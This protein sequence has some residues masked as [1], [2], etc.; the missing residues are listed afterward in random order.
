MF[1]N[2]IKKNVDNWINSYDCPIKALINYIK[3]K[4]ELR[5][6]QIEAIETYLFLKIKCNNEPLDRIFSK[7]YL[8]TFLNID[9]LEIKSDFRDFLKNNLAAKMLY[10]ISLNKNTDEGEFV[11]LKKEIEKNYN[12]I[13][14]E[15]VF[16]NIFYDTSY[17]DYI[18]SLPMG[19][20]KT[21]L[22]AM[23][24]Y[25]D[26]YFAINEPNNKSFAHNFIILAPS[27]LKS[28]IVP[29]LKTIQNFD[30]SW[31][32]PEPSASS[33]KRLVKFEILDANKS[34][35]KSN[36]T[37]NP[38]VNK[39][40]NY[41]PFDSL[42]GLVM[43]T[44]AEK[45]IL[46][47]IKLNEN[48]QIDILDTSEDEEDKQANE[49]RNLIGKVPNLAIY[50]DEVHHA[51]DDDI[52]LRQVVNSWNEKG[53][54][55]AVVGFSGTP[56]LN[57]KEPIE[58]L[59]NEFSFKTGTLTNV[60]YYYPLIKGIG[61]FLKKPIVKSTNDDAINIVKSGVKEFLEK[62]KDKV[63]KNG[64]TAKLAIYC[65]KIDKL[66]KDIYPKVAEIVSEYGL[67]PNQVILKYHQGNKEFPISTESKTEFLSLDTKISKKKIVLLVQI[68]KEGWDCKSLTGVILSQKG[69][70]PTNMVLQTSCR[71]LRQVIKGENEDAIIWL[72]DFNKKI[73]EKELNNQQHITIKEF[74]AGIK[75]DK[76]IKRIDRTQHL[77]LDK[78]KYIEL[79][80]SYETIIE[81]K[82]SEK[83]I[84][85]NLNSIYVELKEL[86]NEYKKDEIVIVKSDIEG[87]NATTE[88]K[89]DYGEELASYSKWLLEI[90]KESMNGISIK[91]LR[92]YN[93]ILKK[94]Y[95]LIILNQNN[96][97]FFN[98]QLNQEKI[99]EDIRKTFYDIYTLDVKEE[100][101]EQTA[102]ILNV[103]GLENP[104][105][106][107]DVNLLFPDTL[108]EM[109]D[110]ISK[111]NNV[112]EK[113]L[114]DY[115]KEELMELIRSGKNQYQINSN[116]IAVKN[117]EKTL[118]YL[119][120]YF[121][122]SGFEKNFIQLVLEMNEFKN[123]NLEIYYNGDKSLT[124]F[125]IKAY[126]KERKN[127]KYLGLYT[128]DFIIIKRDI[129]NNINKILIVETKGK[130]YGQQQDFLDRRKYMNEIF[131]HKNNSAFGYK[132]FDY[133]YIEDTMSSGDI[134]RNIKE[135]INNFFKEG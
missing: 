8:D 31:I 11:D 73:L 92:E 38:N 27:G 112:K 53:S 24:I 51:A 113:S 32:I 103:K 122:Q 125:R 102:S 131:L 75:D 132:K 82:A 87:K 114:E 78:I 72:N 62:Y 55:N 96:E 5:D 98:K 83:N 65:G 1:Y 133:L 91:K 124:E 86:N 100:T 66:E 110:I 47:R 48:S 89:E 129:Q 23:F 34:G 84:I 101:I 126:K 79:K 70:C 41:Q 67:D 54:I 94:I 21:F 29:S 3:S 39:I 134:K 63:Y 19:S 9:E 46:N 118:H 120:Y 123:S 80:L 60:V 108:K 61:N 18:F 128:P 105:Y 45:V 12:R 109:E 104:L 115:T 37:K 30:V 56:Y 77:N 20:G 44:N 14:F 6:T 49:L 95:I 117:S 57:K 85:K 16:N 93:D 4:G 81:K 58:V 50:I 127:L 15:T 52:K 40:A 13:S 116:S 69:D 25:L 26:L 135:K 111:D 28:S 76:S 64:T 35:S 106:E 2:L 90:S 97:M 59:K 33:L 22:M 17:T 71:C 42:I 36:K 130:G 107:Y 99:K 119:P 74:E 7:G 10:S 88:N 43:I 121:A 68:G